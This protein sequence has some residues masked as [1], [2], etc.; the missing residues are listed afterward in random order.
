MVESFLQR[1]V[2][3]I[4]AVMDSGGSNTTASNMPILIWIP[5]VQMFAVTFTV[6]LRATFEIITVFYPIRPYV[7]ITWIHFLKTITY[8]LPREITFFKCLLQNKFGFTQFGHMAELGK[9]LWVR[10]EKNLWNI[11]HYPENNS[12]S[13]IRIFNLKCPKFKALGEFLQTKK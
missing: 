1:K 6:I 3:Q 12:V 11:V 7:Q 10:F 4:I 9:I 5:K 13:T 8:Q 2:Y